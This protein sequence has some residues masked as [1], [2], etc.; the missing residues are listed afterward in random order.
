MKRPMGRLP[1]WA[2][3]NQ[4]SPNSGRQ[5]QHVQPY[6]IQQNRES[7]PRCAVTAACRHWAAPC[8]SAASRPMRHPAEPAPSSLPP[9]HLKQAFTYTARFDV[10]KAGQHKLHSV[11]GD[12]DAMHFTVQQGP[13][14]DVYSARSA[15]RGP[16]M[17]GCHRQPFMVTR[18][19][20]RSK[21]S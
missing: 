11:A 5:W 12:A 15:C 19:L 2:A 4:P 3:Q 21:T 17:Q 7:V 14:H 18:Q 13:C 1:E 16:M 9:V 10:Y 20:T 6:A 8:Q